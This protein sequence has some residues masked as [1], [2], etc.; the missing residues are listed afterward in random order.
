MVKLVHRTI[1]KNAL[2]CIRVVALNTAQYCW[3]SQGIVDRFTIST[4]AIKVCL[5]AT[6]MMSLS[7]NLALCRAGRNKSCNGHPKAMK[8]LTRDDTS[9]FNVHHGND[10]QPDP[11]K[12]RSVTAR[13][14][15][16]KA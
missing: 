10:L 1:F 9:D 5:Q 14:T 2:D 13:V 6:E 11:Y 15:Q 7:T 8:A 4:T 3:A 16:S 12:R